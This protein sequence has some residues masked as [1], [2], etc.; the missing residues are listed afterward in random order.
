[1]MTHPLRVGSL[2]SGIG[3]FERA[4]EEVELPTDLAF[5]CEVNP[6]ASRAYALLHNVK[7]TM[8]LGDITQ[9]QADQ[10]PDFD[11]MTYGFPCFVA[12]TTIATKKGYKPIETIQAGDLVL[13]HTNTYQTVL[14]TMETVTDHLHKLT[15]LVSEDVYTTEEHPF[16]VR[17]RSIDG[18][19]HVHYS[20]PKWVAAKDLTPNHYV[21]LAINKENSIPTIVGFPQQ[22]LQ[23]VQCWGMLGRLVQGGKIVEQEP[24]TTDTLVEV[25]CTSNEFWTLSGLLHRFNVAYTSNKTQNGYT[26]TVNHPTLPKLIKKWKVGDEI[27]ITP[28]IYHLPKAYLQAFL[29]GVFGE[30]VHTQIQY[31]GS[32]SES[33]YAMGQALMKAFEVPYTVMPVQDKDDYKYLLLHDVGYNTFYADGYIWTAIMRN[34]RT[35]VRVPVFNLHVDN[36]NSYTV[37]NMIVHNCQD[38]SALGSMRGFRTEAGE[39]TRSGLFYEAMRIA[40]AKRPAYLIAENVRMLVSKSF[41]KEFRGMLETLDQL[42]YNTYTGVLNTK[43]YEL[44]HSRTR[45][46]IVSIRKDVDDGAFN[47]PDKVPLTTLASDYYD[48]PTSIS[49]DHYLN[50]HQIA[51]YA[52][53]FRLKKKYSSLNADIIICQTTKQGQKSTSQNFVKDSRGVR[54]MTAREQLRLQGFRTTDAD[55]LTSNGFTAKQIG[56]LSGNSISVNV[57]AHIYRNLFAQQLQKTDTQTTSVHGAAEIAAG[58]AARSSGAITGSRITWIQLR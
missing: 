48:D 55:L 27:R 20:K 9:V 51:K 18:Q 10:L 7:E 29:S 45:V 14:Q 13:T 15:T 4:F 2:F 44:P 8:N 40:K 41:T 12:G 25:S 23:T 52:N 36:D 19:D 30:N 22:T 49:A 54:I 35:Q 42:G 32:T 33:V 43:D 37:N 16:Y 28:H 5:Y 38:L 1:M 50:E 56:Q 6:I 26:L 47:F 11:V 31:E 21:G 3:A 58:A 46:F 17:E 39:L 57:L 24:S 53:E 34:E